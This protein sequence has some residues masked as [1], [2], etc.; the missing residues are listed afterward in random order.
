MLYLS[1]D[2]FKMS[3]LESGHKAMAAAIA[4][5]VDYNHLSVYMTGV[6]DVVNDLLAKADK[7]DGE[8]A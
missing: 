2:E 4:G 3:V 8:N 7:D 6:M 1:H 5:A